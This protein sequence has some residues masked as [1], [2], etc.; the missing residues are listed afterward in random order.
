[1]LSVLMILCLFGLLGGE[2]GDIKD[3]GMHGWVKFNLRIGEAGY[4]SL[5]V[6]EDVFAKYSQVT[7]LK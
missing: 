3:H 6:E 4:F 5:F 1:M 2:V 7:K